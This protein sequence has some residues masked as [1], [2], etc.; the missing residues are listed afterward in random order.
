MSVFFSYQQ[1][2]RSA[3][4][5]IVT[6]TTDTLL[7][8]D[9]IA[10]ALGPIATELAELNHKAFLPDFKHG[11]FVVPRSQKDTANIAV[12]PVNHRQA[13]RVEQIVRPLLSGC[14]SRWPVTETMTSE[15]YGISTIPTKVNEPSPNAAAKKAAGFR[16]TTAART[17]SNIS[18]DK[19]YFTVSRPIVAMRHNLLKGVGNISCGATF[20]HELVH[21]SDILTDGVAY[22]GFL[23]GAAS[24]CRAYN[25]DAT[26][27][28]IALGSVT[29]SVSRKMEA[30]RKEH[31]GDSV[32]PYTPNT[33]LL[34]AMVRLDVI[35]DSATPA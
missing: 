35:S 20:A 28:Q 18:N 1:R 16:V 21:A 22:S 2:R 27:S 32:H 23:Y 8:D 26:I 24:E 9:R 13:A 30:L 17:M 4:F 5:D 11:Q 12:A 31:I 29:N 34:Q 7:Q 10:L 6:E 3:F 25:V 33:A 19:D 15:R 14:I